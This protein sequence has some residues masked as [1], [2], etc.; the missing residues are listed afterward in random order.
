[1][2]QDADGPRI[3]GHVM[4]MSSTVQLPGGRGGGSDELPMEIGSCPCGHDQA[5]T[6]H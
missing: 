3:H 1:M 6:A 2:C 5:S 4:E